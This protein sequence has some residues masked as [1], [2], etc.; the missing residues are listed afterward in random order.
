MTEDPAFSQDAHVSIRELFVVPWTRSTFLVVLEVIYHASNCNNKQPRTAPSFPIIQWTVTMEDSGVVEHYTMP[1]HRAP[2]HH[3]HLTKFAFLL[4]SAR[5][6]G[7][8]VEPVVGFN[9][10]IQMAACFSS[11]GRQCIA[12]SSLSMHGTKATS[13]QQGRGEEKEVTKA[14]LLD[15]AVLNMA[16]PFFTTPTTATYTAKTIL[17]NIVTT[18]ETLID[19]RL[20]SVT[21]QIVLKSQPSVTENKYSKILLLLLSPTLRPVRVATVITR[22]MIIPPPEKNE[23]GNCDELGILTTTTTTTT[24]GER[25]S[26]SSVTE[27]SIPLI[28][29]AVLDIKVFGEVSTIELSCPVTISGTFDI[30]DTTAG[31]LTNVDIVFDTE[32]LLR[33]MIDHARLVVK[34][35]V[36]KA[37]ATSVNVIQLYNA[38]GEP[39]TTSTLPISNKT[40]TATSTMSLNSLTTNSLFGSSVLLDTMTSLD[41]KALGSLFSSFSQQHQLQK[42]SGSTVAVEKGESSYGLLTNNNSTIQTIKKNS[43]SSSPTTSTANATFDLKNDTT[44]TTTTAINSRNISTST[45]RFQISKSPSPST[46]PI[47]CNLTT[48]NEDHVSSTSTCTTHPLLVQQPHSH[49]QQQLV[50]IQPQSQCQQPQDGGETSNGNVHAGLFSWLQNDSMFLT[51]NQIEEANIADAKRELARSLVPMPLRFFTANTDISD[52]RYQ[53]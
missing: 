5:S 50:S 40:T 24:T 12:S 14:S 23:N 51:D 26:S 13:L 21:S 35:A 11:S 6:E 38:K 39:K 47:T 17:K 30:H 49:H 36:T 4:S 18:F 44:T 34:L 1:Q 2:Q 33:H 28:F 20:R 52:L 3:H 46:T 7:S 8:D 16:T 22:F 43:N 32:H 19:S 29:K 48:C 42:R 27:L 45:V 10:D 15:K 41:P 9:H 37:A 31:L 53:G 25:D